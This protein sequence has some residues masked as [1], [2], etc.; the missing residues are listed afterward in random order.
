M[1]GDFLALDCWSDRAVWM[2]ELAFPSAVYM[3]TKYP[4]AA[5]TWLPILYARRGLTGVSRLMFS[6][7]AGHGH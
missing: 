6:R 4:D 7:D 2:K 5:D 1:V 3:R